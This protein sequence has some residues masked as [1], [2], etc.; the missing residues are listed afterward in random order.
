MMSTSNLAPWCLVP[1]ARPVQPE[2]MSMRHIVAGLINTCGRAP[3]G[4]KE[5]KI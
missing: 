2:V 5:K 3:P 4:E 1:D